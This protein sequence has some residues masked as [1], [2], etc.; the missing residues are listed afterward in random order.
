M[1]FDGAPAWLSPLVSVV[2]LCLIVAICRW[3]F[4]TADRGRPA[5]GTHA[6]DLGLLE[7]VAQVRTRADAEMLRELL[8]QA[9]VRAGISEEADGI[10][11]LVFRH[12]LQLARE[13]V[14][15]D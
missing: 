13:L 6:Q 11:V 5:H 7:P 12:D 9:G 3:V 1:L 4:S 2:A 10:Q 14:A 8:G 15:A